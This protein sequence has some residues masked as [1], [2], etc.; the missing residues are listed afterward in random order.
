MSI[1]NWWNNNTNNLLNN[2]NNN[3]NILFPSI[4]YNNISKSFIET[5]YNLLHCNHQNICNF[6]LDNSKLT[7]NNEEI[8]G[9][10]LIKQK[11]A[12]LNLK[13]PKFTINNF[14]AQP[15]DNNKIIITVIGTMENKLNSSILSFNISNK[16][17]YHETF[18]LVNN[19][20]SWFIQNHIFNII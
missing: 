17:N 5:Y 1:F 10:E 18:I 3:L 11:Y 8:L 6:Y 9:I 15:I 7:Y 19:N 16:N 14:N 20:N 4:H 2:L 12:N 13:E